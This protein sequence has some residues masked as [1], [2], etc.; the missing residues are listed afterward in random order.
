M[1][2][3][4]SVIKYKVL[5]KKKPINLTKLKDISYGVMSKNYYS[6]QIKSS[7]IFFFFKKNK[8]E[9]LKKKIN[10]LNPNFRTG[11]VDAE[12]SFLV[13]IRKLPGYKSGIRVE[14][15]FQI[16]MDKKDRPL[17]EL[18]KSFFFF[19]LRVGK[20]SEAL[21]SVEL[22]VSSLTDLTNIIIP[23]FEKYPLLTQKKADFEIFKLIVKLIN[24]K[25]H[26]TY[27]G[28]LE[29]VSFKKKKSFY[30]FRFILSI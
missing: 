6:S 7:C 27:E 23:H 20:I 4:H 24:D 2:L 21:T 29:I 14:T 22:R 25:K 28:I 26:L 10:I 1:N 5:K 9:I 13:L 15:R 3:T 17:L 18:I 16:G 12:G 11:F 30:E 19:F 8:S